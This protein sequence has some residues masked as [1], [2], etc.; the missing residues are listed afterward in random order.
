MFSAQ[1][2]NFCKTTMSFTYY[3]PVPRS[4]RFWVAWT[5]WNRHPAFLPKVQ[6][7]KKS[8]V[9]PLGIA[10]KLHNCRH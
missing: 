2:C 6:T 7:H 4:Y 5:R 3:A 8:M 10:L 1:T 9:A